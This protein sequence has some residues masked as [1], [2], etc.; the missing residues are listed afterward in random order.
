M[1]V[2][3]L[4]L[5]KIPAGEL[6]LL[7]WIIVTLIA[8]VVY[9]FVENRWGNKK[10]NKTMLDLNTNLVSLQG[11]SN[12]VICDLQES[13]NNNNKT[14]AEIRDIIKE[15]KLGTDIVKDIKAAAQGKR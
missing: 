6:Q 10:Y 5:H 3:E 14:Q 11:Q 13:I 7:H 4:P 9:L 12:K 2:Q 15:L 8:V 1:P